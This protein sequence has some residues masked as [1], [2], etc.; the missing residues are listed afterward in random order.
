M[1][2]SR[3]LDFLPDF[4]K[5]PANRRFLGST[6]DQ[7]ISEPATKKFNG[8]IGRQFAPV[9]QNGDS[10][11]QE[12][13]QDRQNY[14]LEPSVVVSDEN[15][16]VEFYASY[17]DILQ[18]INFYGG[19]TDNQNRLFD[20][21]SYTYNGNYDLDKVVNFA[22]YY[23]LPNGPDSVGVGVGFVPARQDYVITVDSNRRSYNV[24]LLPGQN[25]DIPVRRGGR[26]D[27]DVSAFGGG[28]YIQTE[29]TIDGFSANNKNLSVR[30]T[31]NQGVVENGGTL[32]LVTFN[33]PAKDSQDAFK[34]MPVGFEADLATNLRYKDIAN[35]LLSEVVGIDGY[36]GELDNKFIVFVEQTND[37]DDWT[38]QAA[39]SPLATQYPSQLIDPENRS[40]VYKINIVDNDD[41]KIITL[42]AF[43]NTP[44]NTRISIKSGDTFSGLQYY[45]NN[46]NLLEQF[47]VIITDTLY[48]VSDSD[49]LLV[50]KIKII[51]TDTDSVDLERDIIGQAN[52]TSTNGVEFTNGLKIQFDE[53]VLP[54]SYRNQVYYVEGVGSSIRLVPDSGQFSTPDY[55]TVNR[56]SIDFNQWS[57][58][59]R[60]THE[61]VIRAA[62]RYNNTSILFDQTKRAQRPIIEFDADLQLFNYG[63]EFAGTVTYFDQT[64]TDAFGT[65]SSSNFAGTTA[66]SYQ[67]NTLQSGDTIIFSKDQ[68]LE[69]RSTIYEIL[70]VELDSETTILLLPKQTINEFQ[71]V[72][73]QSG[74]YADLYF[75]YENDQW[76]ASQSKTS[77][78][79]YPLF[80]IVDDDYNSLSTFRLSDFAG[81]RLFSY[82][83]GNGNVDPV[84]G[85][86][87]SYKNI[88]NLG[89]IEFANNYQT[90]TFK[91]A[92]EQ[93]FITIDINTGFVVKNISR[94]QQKKLNVWNKSLTR[95]QQYQ[96]YTIIAD[97]VNNQY[98]FDLIP[99]EISLSKAEVKV[100]V[101]NKLKNLDEYQ[102]TVS[103]STTIEFNQV[104]VE[105]SRI[106]VLILSNQVDPLAFYQIPSNL[107]NNSLNSE[108]ESL[109]LG[110]IRN[111]AKEIFSTH[112]DLVGQELG[113]NNIRN[114]QYRNIPGTILQHSSPL[115]YT[116]L[117]LTHPEA[118]IVDSIYYAQKEYNRFK[119]RFLETAARLNFQSEE[120]IPQYIDEI[121]SV[122]NSA[123]GPDSPWYYSDMVPFG[124][125]TTVY[126]YE[127]LDVDVDNYLIE[128]IFDN[129]V[130]SNRAVLVY[131][132]GQQLL[133]DQD[134]YFSESLP[135]IILKES[136]TRQLGDI[137]TIVNYNN[138]DGNFIPETPT[139]LGL[140]PKFLPQIFVDDRY[141]EPQTVI[142]GHD[143]SITIA[144][145][146]YRDQLL[147]ELEKRIYNNI[148]AVYD[149]TNKN[150]LW[151]VLPGKFRDN[152]YSRTEF[153]QI[154]SR[155]FLKWV[156]SNQLDYIT[157][158]Y[159]SSN[160]PKTWNYKTT[161]SVL[162]NEPLPGNWRAIYRYFYDTDRP[163]THPWEMLGFSE[164]P[165]WWE[166]YYGPAP[167]TGSNLVLWTDLENGIIKD[168]DRAGQDSRFARPGLTAIIPVNEFGELKT[169]DQFLLRNFS[170]EDVSGPWAIGDSGP[171][172]TAWK[173]SSDYPF[174]VQLAVALSKPADYFGLFV[175]TIRYRYN[176]DL[177]QILFEGSNDKV[178][179]QR[180]IL[181]GD[182]T[183]STIG[184][185]SGYINYIV[186]YLT[187]QGMS[188]VA[189]VR[190]LLD[191][192][193]VKLSYRMA[194][195]SDKKL[196]KVFAEQT[197]LGSI[198]DSVLIPNENYQLYLHR[199]TPVRRAVYSSVI[200]RKTTT[201]Y[202]VEGYDYNN[203]FFNIVPSR[204]NGNYFTIKGIDRTARI[205][206]D[207]QS[208]FLT[209][210]YGFEFTNR[211]QVVDF[212][213]SY[214]RYL[215]SQGYI[216]TEFNNDLGQPQN[217][218]LSA[219]EFLTW[220]EQ[221][222]GSDSIIVLSPA[223][224]KLTLVDNTAIVGE[225]D[226]RLTGSRV[227]DQ[228]FSNINPNDYNVI[229]DDDSFELETVNA[230]IIGLAD[231]ALV[232]YEHVLLLDNTTDF[233]DIIYEPSLGSRQ[234]RLKIIGQ[235]TDNWTGRLS[236]PGFIYS[237]GK[238]EEWQVFKDYKQG[239]LIV[240]KNR[241]YSANELV[242]GQQ[243]FDFSKWQLKET[244][245]Q[246]P[247]LLLNFAGQ[248]KKFIDIYDVDGDYIDVDLENFSNNLI[249]FKTRDYF[250]DFVLENKS[251]IK[252]YQGFIK[253]KGTRG[254]V[255]A[256]ANATFNK[257]EGN[258][259]F[260]ENW[261]LKLGTFGAV[262]NFRSTEIVLDE[263]PGTSNPFAVEVVDSSDSVI[264]EFR[265]I[266][267]DQLFVSG[268]NRDNN[269]FVDRNSQ[270][271]I[272][273]QDLISS[274]FVDPNEV[275]FMIFDI[276]NNQTQLEDFV[277]SVGTGTT[278]WAAKD[279]NSQWNVYR[280]TP[281]NFSINL[282]EYGLDN[283]AEISTSTNNNFEPG[284]IVIVKEFD[285][286]LDGVY[287]VLIKESLKTL[288]VGIS[289]E[290]S[291]YLESLVTVESSG[292]IFKLQSSRVD[293]LTKLE[294]LSDFV[295]GNY[296][297][298]DSSDNWRVYQRNQPWDW[299]N[300]I[301]FNEPDS[302]WG[303]SVSVDP[304]ENFL[305]VGCP[306]TGNPRIEYY[307]ISLPTPY[308]FQIRPQ[309]ASSQ[310]F[311][312]AVDQSQKKLYVGDPGYQTETGYLAIYN[313]V[314]ITFS[315][316][317]ILVGDNTGDKLGHSIT[318]S[319]DTRWLY[320]GAPGTEKVLV[321]KLIN[322]TR[323][324]NSLTGTGSV[325]PYTLAF[326]PESTNS[327]RVYKDSTWLV[328]GVDYT[329]VGNQITFSGVVTGEH[330]YYQSSYYKYIDYIELPS[331]TLGDNFGYKIKTTTDGRQLAIGAPDY[332]SQGA[333]FVYD[334]I[335]EAFD[336]QQGQTTFTALRALSEYDVNVNGVRKT[337][338]VDYTNPSGTDIVFSRSLNR[339]DRVEIEIN[340]FVLINSVN[341]DFA[342]TDSQFGISLD[343]CSNNCSL[344]IGQP[345]YQN[346]NYSRGIVSRYS[347]IGRISGQIIS[348]IISDPSNCISTDTSIRINDFEIYFQNTDTGFPSLDYVV[349]KINSANLIGITA[350]K[351]QDDIVPTSYRLK[352]TSDSILTNQ[353]LR[354]LPGFG[355]ALT[356]LGLNVF[357]LV[358]TITKP[359][360]SLLENFGTEVR[361]NGNANALAIASQNA[362]LRFLTTFDD[363]SMTLD[364]NSTMMRDE[365]ARSGAVYIFEMVSDQ[366]PYQNIQQWQANRTYQVNE[367]FAYSQKNYIVKRS[368]TSGA[369]FENNILLIAQITEDHFVYV[370][371]LVPS[372][373][374]GAGNAY[375]KS[376][377]FTNTLSGIVSQSAS[378]GR[379]DLFKNTSQSK[380]W[381]LSREQQ[382]IVDLN[383]VAGISL[384]SR[385]TNQLI[386][387]LDYIDPL[388]GKILGQADQFIDFK[389]AIDPA[390]YNNTSD[391]TGKYFW[392]DQYV[393]KVWW[394]LDDVRYVEYQQK[395]RLYRFDNWAREF[396]GS[397]ISVYEWVESP[398]LPSQYQERGLVGT[399]VYPDDSKYT[400][401]VSVDSQSGILRTQYY[402]WVTDKNTAV[403]GK[404]ISI[405]SIKNLI[406][407]PKLENIP[408]A[409]ILDK[410]SISL[411]NCDKF[412]TGEDVVL[413][414]NTYIQ[415]KDLPV[416]NEWL[417]LQQKSNTVIP[418]FL[419]NKVIDSLL[420]NQVVNGIVKLVPDPTLPEHLKYG[421][422]IRP[423]QSMFRDRLTASKIFI[424]YI[425]RELKKV[426]LVGRKDLDNLS[427]QSP[428]PTES[429]YDLVF[430]D[431][432]ELVSVDISAIDGGT[433]ILILSDSNLN[434]KWS[435]YT[436]N[437]NTLTLTDFQSYK[438]ENYWNYVDW[439]DSAY[440]PKTIPDY[441]VETFDQVPT[442]SAEIGQ[443]VKVKNT[444]N[445]TWGVYQVAEST[446]VPVALQSATIE[447]DDIL[448]DPVSAGIGFDT[449]NFDTGAFDEN[450]V[451]DFRLIFQALKNDIVV[452]DLSYIF[453]GSIFALIEYVFYEQQN[454]DWIFKTSFIDVVHQ[455]R[456]LIA[457][458]SYV[459]DNQDYYRQ[460]IEEV[461]PYKTKIRQYLLD[462]T[463]EDNAEMDLTDFDF[464]VYFDQNEN[465][466]RH[467]AADSPLLQ[468]YPWK[469]WNDNISFSIETVSISYTGFGYQVEPTL[470]PLGG[471]GS[472][473]LRSNVAG[474]SV[475]SVTVVNGGSGFFSNVPIEVVPSVNPNG[476][477]GQQA[478]LLARVNNKKVRTSKIDI[479]FDRIEY[480]GS[481][482]NWTSNTEYR[483][484]DF[485]VNDD[486][487][488]IISE[489]FLSGASFALPGTGVGI[490]YRLASSLDLNSAMKRARYYYIPSSTM[491]PND[492]KQLF[493]GIEYP[494]V[495]VQSYSFF[496]TSSNTEITIGD[497]ETE[498]LTL[499]E[500]IS[501]V[502]YQ[503]VKVT[504]G[505]NYFKAMVLSFD[506]DSNELSVRVIS[507]VGT[508]TFSSWTVEAVEIDEFEID[509]EGAEQ[510]DLRNL[511][512]IYRSQFIDTSL[513]TRAE[514]ID[515]QGGRFV[516]TAHSHAPEELVPGRIY[517][518][519][520]IRVFNRLSD[521]SHVGFR[522]FYNMNTNLEDANR[523]P[524]PTVQILEPMTESSTSVKVV[525][526]Y[527]QYELMRPVTALSQTLPIVINGEYM[528]YSAYDPE[529]NIISGITRA[530]NGT[531]A[532]SHPVGSFVTVLNQMKN[533]REYYRISEE[534]TAILSQDLLFNSVVIEVE[535][536]SVL[537][538]PSST[539]NIPGV[540]FV[541]GERI[542]YWTIDYENNKLGQLVRGVHGTGVPQVHSVGS[543]A[544][545]A[546]VQQKIPDGDFVVWSQTSTKLEDSLTDQ[547]DFLKAKPSYNP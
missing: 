212:L 154:I 310:L 332:D 230:K 498:T 106:D 365:I 9:Y 255:N 104:L 120:F 292:M 237:N 173:S 183:S 436:V 515:V 108:F 379:V 119:N 478:T 313:Q 464:P 286:V 90:D 150:V 540:I 272:Y 188:G 261:A 153:D 396:P 185:S 42:T 527:T 532:R 222:W 37:D 314:G 8:Y 149:L 458:P 229:R 55:F 143:G 462:Y 422:S 337:L 216:F 15:N 116:G 300:R 211:Q 277:E 29:P 468:Q 299:S 1:A 338:G 375:G 180:I 355:N 356:S 311:G 435:I 256:L 254:A 392:A 341:G 405:T 123:K 33:V 268:L 46:Q 386:S 359:R 168:G 17:S 56:A 95:S 486:K 470:I 456:K 487:I 61:S 502:P 224:G 27:Y 543:K 171:V 303:D 455:L 390:V 506:S 156:G 2:T 83:T 344:Y 461:K 315:L 530:V 92:P 278:I 44:T 360:T 81:T 204:N 223:I 75:H 291:Q 483:K 147:L 243:E 419:S 160:S 326:T 112:R 176:S 539:D 228:N 349:N 186:E 138:T 347:N 412:L 21:Q 485:F 432:S 370:H 281:T 325:G 302:A 257:L 521:N 496:S 391:I 174:A 475:N 227:L 51:D 263:R 127:V 535:D 146:D 335:I 169:P 493:S 244:I 208:V 346:T 152:E 450:P 389:S 133:L 213:I 187:G 404:N 20:N 144:F 62:A 214:Q 181:N 78:N 378:Q 301:T 508:G 142:Q 251:Q 423:R 39:P 430:D 140:Y 18:Q 285:E 270:T 219:R 198:N 246:L 206:R 371:D 122:I 512:V 34:A 319:K 368:F 383:S 111:H 544:V 545:D 98:Q 446:L 193:D 439:Y 443:L 172:E 336:S 400:Q 398:V 399:P 447:F 19:L 418:E 357:K 297:Y 14:Q 342:Q 99:I 427:A 60:W 497:N 86:P 280:A 165:N 328:P 434:N 323:Q 96:Q 6:L 47:P 394:N 12:P 522:L 484:D 191:R 309:V 215:N 97:G 348:D 53:F 32:G 546:S 421:I 331:P 279:Y 275:D 89:D 284:D 4:L 132:N 80:D 537:P 534:N 505:D 366:E 273:N 407:N 235:K 513:G 538:R 489:D 518:T 504:N 170:G 306:I 100:Y 82:K 362:N 194:G 367:L 413:R 271:G 282:I 161:V 440:D 74:T 358:Q 465:R 516:D 179:S 307:N 431:L 234:Y 488:Y 408:Y 110:Q 217:W 107:E 11:I 380:F 438:L 426:I 238:I 481:I 414:V 241:V 467:P 178:K 135:S 445:N 324:I 220:S 72:R 402:F 36:L 525:E 139:K 30:L 276:K 221:G 385:S 473:R 343:I 242:P 45:K 59:N 531:T 480:D 547:A 31:A 454:P 65:E 397:N 177:D 463:G 384:Y 239:D 353:K 126:T 103:G 70:L 451:S 354:L 247:Q 130:A 492:V 501:V 345:G 205:Y 267:K 509:R 369:A 304:N 196:L 495:K 441:V 382:P 491:T 113:S 125:D 203:P 452:D 88:N 265:Q 288:I 424:E 387:R 199:S 295:I 231:L 101:D 499:A 428:L 529:T 294:N 79:Q 26:Y 322:L 52:Y 249:G 381:I 67:S 401:I 68:D 411:Y 57:R 410:N 460:Y 210:P 197:S 93:S 283:T 409:A 520:E 240:Y 260:Y 327:L 363:A 141:N 76:I 533:T 28:F 437:G 25:P 262:D 517:D 184:R 158:S 449:L 40:D 477:F 471:D 372:L 457:Y 115:I 94:I 124:A 472:A 10:Y 494:G 41:E 364:Q 118:N 416:H 226:G 48:Y 388:R 105:G 536:A 417:L 77:V 117:F 192:L 490:N 524:E 121:M 35:K 334:R 526:F 155:S 87:L 339:N 164:R 403:T 54:E 510:P 218:E 373:L 207:F 474:G 245:S 128:N 296:I 500:T 16:R 175:D 503:Y 91:Y 351:I 209:I 511:D 340:E 433:R 22:N 476:T 266:Y 264:E 137:I 258:I 415:A 50:G 200:V 248:A 316:D 274:G 109:T 479:K 157:N 350:E 167:Y 507:T 38:S 308:R 5:T 114:L 330:V 395:D 69:V 129:R 425:N 469:F 429:Q 523:N 320:V 145:G 253:E 259:E 195:F 236:T 376:F 163:H 49:P 58:S 71:N 233:D 202:A 541:N 290:K 312:F 134:Y 318:S 102:L 23:W 482:Q 24:D 189:T 151:N 64:I 352:I 374:I 162:D 519:L 442:L 542:H 43:Y 448:Y 269:L 329:V 250:D 289:P 85:I 453:V 190:R 514:D 225:I 131:F 377:I 420:G 182:N 459:K 3:S 201:G 466:Y 528:T 252:F 73:I 66:L 321:Y 293:K 63:R 148:K 287:Q 393:G 305:I 444:G 317:Q 136:L 13:D 406:Q 166:Q 333:V 84:L 298:N 232:K 7:L 361:V 159:F